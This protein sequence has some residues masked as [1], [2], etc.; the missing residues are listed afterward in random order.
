MSSKRKGAGSKPASPN[1][2]EALDDD[3]V[4]DRQGTATPV[5]SQLLQQLVAQNEQAQ[6]QSMAK[7]DAM[8]LILQ[9]QTTALTELRAANPTAPPQPPPRTPEEDAA[10]A[11]ATAAAT[12][13]S[14]AATAA[15][16]ASAT[17]VALD[18]FAD[19]L[20]QRL[21]GS[22]KA[23]KERHDALAATLSSAS[24][25]STASGSYSGSSA[26]SQAFLTPFRSPGSYSSR[27]SGSSQGLSG[28]SMTSQPLQGVGVGTGANATPLGGQIQTATAT[29]PPPPP[30]NDNHQQQP[31]Q[32][33]PQQQH[34]SVAQPPWQGVQLSAAL[35]KA[36]QTPVPRLKSLSKQHIIQFDKD[37]DEYNREF[38]SIDPK[39]MR[40][41]GSCMAPD[42]VDIV[43]AHMFGAEGPSFGTSDQFLS[44]PDQDQRGGLFSLYHVTT[45]PA[46]ASWL[47][48]LPKTQSPFD[49]QAFHAYTR[50]FNYSVRFLGP[51]FAEVASK[52]VKSAYVDGLRPSS[53]SQFVQ[54]LKLPG[55]LSHVQALAARTLPQ[56]LGDAAA[57]VTHPSTTAFTS[58]LANTMPAPRL[59]PATGSPNVPNR[60]GGGG[61][62]LTEKERA[63]RLAKVQCRKCAKFGHYADKCPTLSSALPP[64]YPKKIG[65]QQVE[66]DPLN[67][68]GE[69]FD[70]D[71]Q[72]DDDHDAESGDVAD[73]STL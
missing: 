6:Q 59:M 50:L 55:Q 22:D 41:A 73:E 20:F 9:Q 51:E 49:I 35:I 2:F 24:T 48:D 46:L 56:F 17:T 36:M 4:D 14:N 58:R 43:A 44:L 69:E 65:V 15:A 42:D 67:S 3:D 8:L 68:E 30:P 21:D 70:G 7:F 54:S 23:H 63:D 25:A 10:A 31:H 37:L 12:A 18:G 66:F 71:R 60:T 52:A 16:V 11:A 19:R 62:P 53:F 40:K 57:A 64:P 38:M 32:Q 5:V 27:S 26:R 1:R 13:A 45:P 28:Y 33:Q 47:R 39:M 34:H 61:T 72:Y 29:A